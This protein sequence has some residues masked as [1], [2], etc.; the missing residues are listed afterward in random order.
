MALQLAEFEP[1]IECI[2]IVFP[3]LESVHFWWSY[4]TVNSL[5]YIWLIVGVYHDSATARQHDSTI[6]QLRDSTTTQ[7]RNGT[8]AS[9][10][11]DTTERQ[12]GDITA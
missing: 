1:P 9:Q 11:D 8:T 10:H 6:A 4:S 3:P 12:H 5:L 7:R 2:L